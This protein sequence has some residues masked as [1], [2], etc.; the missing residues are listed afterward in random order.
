[1][2]TYNNRK[3]T[4]NTKSPNRPGMSMLLLC[5]AFCCCS[6]TPPPRVATME[7]DC[8]KTGLEIRDAGNHLYAS[9]WFEAALAQHPQEEQKILRLLVESQIRAGR[10]LAAQ[11][12]LERLQQLNAD[13][14]SLG[15]LAL[16]IQIN[17]T[18]PKPFMEVLP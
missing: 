6:T 7:I 16:A 12:G 17:K 9:Y 13:D 18:T 10:L 2:T 1:M 11:S 14:P 8:L 4:Q 3:A 15:T 5:L